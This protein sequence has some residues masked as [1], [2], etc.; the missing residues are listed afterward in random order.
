MSLLH[1][2]CR[3]IA[4]AAAFVAAS[5]SGADKPPPG[6]SAS[7]VEL[8]GYTMMNGHP[9][10]K[11]TM[12]RAGDRWYIIGG[13]YNVPGWS[14]IDVTDPRNPRVAKFIP[15]PPNTSTN[16]VDF[17]DGILVASLVRPNNRLDAGLDPKNPFQAGV[18][19]IDMKDP[20]NPKE[21]GRWL[22]DKPNGRGTHR[23]LYQGGRYVHLAADMQ[24]YSGDIYVILD[25]SNPAKPVEAGRW[26]VPGQNFG[27]GETP[28]KDPIVN[29]HNPNF[30]DANN[31]VYLSYGD[32]GM[33][34]LDINDPSKPKLVSRTKFEPRHRFDVHTVTPFYKR[35]LVIANSESVT[36]KCE[37]PL[38]HVTIVDV[39]NPA[40]PVSL[41]RFPVPIPPADAPY[42]SFCDKG[43]RF[44]P[45]N[46][47]QLQHNPH[48]EKQGNLAYVTWFN[49]GLR[50]YDI[51]NVRLPREVGHFMAGAP[52]KQYLSY[53]G[54]YVRM[55]DVFVDAR[56]YIYLTGGAQQGLYILRYT[57]P[58]K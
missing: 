33:V 44:G 2:W 9:A 29:L 17:A 18:M 46:Q 37:G 12:T 57:G 5:A 42:T 25:I 13:H 43:G 16:Q 52:E 53:Y 56:G 40:N 15:G 41:S 39:A 50:V 49:A 48:V 30:V 36:Y 22:T 45:H 32:A 35:K 23:N 19:L 58:R 31:H 26:W 14:V 10:F 47:N 11:I 1:S 8:V 54:P 6:W 28:Q 21:L 38:D 34:V 51:S 27:A 4:F 7:N 55:E 3:R 24:G 20:L